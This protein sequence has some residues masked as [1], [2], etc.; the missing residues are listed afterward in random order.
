[1]SREYPRYAICAVGAVLISDGRILLVRRGSEPG[2]GLWGVPGGVIEVGEDLF[3]A[4]Q[5]ELKE[6]TGI[7]A[8]PVGVL[9]IVNLVVM[10]EG[11]RV[12][13]HYVIL[14]VLFDERTVRGELKPGGDAIEAT[15]M[16]LDEVLARSD[17][18]KPTK[19]LVSLLINTNKGDL[20]VLTPINIIV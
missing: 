5:R 2:K 15:F 3:M 6:E 9:G 11:N 1:M 18:S 19:I 7:D 4:A 16:A 17:I 20:A 12:K 13:Y 10:D 8:K 14:N